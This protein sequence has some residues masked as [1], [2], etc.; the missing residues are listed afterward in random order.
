ALHDLA[1]DS[2]RPA[3]PASP[4]RPGPVPSPEALLSRVTVNAAL[5]PLRVGTV[6][7]SSA[8]KAV[9][10]LVALPGKL[11]GGVVSG[12]GGGSVPSFPPKTR[13]NQTVSPHRVFEARFHDL[14]DFKRIK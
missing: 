2:P 1:A 12:V 8:P 11:V 10:G 14:A 13:F 6:L 5:H 7:A 4:W 3:G 9:R